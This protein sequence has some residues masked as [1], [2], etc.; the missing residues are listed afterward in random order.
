[1][2]I[3]TAVEAAYVPEISGDVSSA[4]CS[5]AF[6]LAKSMFNSKASRLYAPLRIPEEMNSEMV[7]GSSAL[8][9]SGGAALDASEDQ[10][11]RVSQLGE[12]TARSVYWGKHARIGVRIAVKERSVGWR[13][14]MYS[15]YLLDAN[16]EKS[17]FLKDAQEGYGRSRY[18]A[19]VEGTW[20]P[21]LVFVMNSNKKLWFVTVGEP[22]QV[23]ANWT[24]YKETISGFKQGCVIRFRP[25]GANAMTLLPRS[26]QK[27]AHL[28][29]KTIGPGNDEGTLQPTTQLRIQAQ[30]VWANAALRPWALSD[31]D[32]YNSTDEVKGGLIAWSHNGPSYRR[33]HEEILRTYPL[34]EN[35]LGNHYM[36]QFH[37]PK[38]KANSLAKW[39]L[40]I[41]FR[42][43]YTFSNGQDYF[44]YDN[45]NTNPW[46]DGY[47][48]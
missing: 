15:L 39:V 26:V 5:S 2:F 3:S 32:T 1:M 27:L 12:D 9:I 14:D 17:E 13:G 33:I 21:P 20:R 10:F 22:Y 19:L 35:A 45:V 30:H 8:D 34:A 44:R 43:N 38:N 28:L 37:L 23:L 42:A 4:E 16:V 24:I 48:R 36:R 11:E 7:L 40:D 6:R 46:N 29:D 41:A 47:K 25:K 31:S 18:S